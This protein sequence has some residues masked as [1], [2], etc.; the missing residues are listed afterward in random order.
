MTMEELGR[1]YLATADK[2]KE[3]IDQLKGGSGK[4]NDSLYQRIRI[5]KAMEADTRI[6]GARL[7]HY[8][9]R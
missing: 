5:L 7:V 1:D 2:L 4:I 6:T 9:E 3:R 8:Y